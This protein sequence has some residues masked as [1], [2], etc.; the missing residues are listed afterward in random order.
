MYFRTSISYTVPILTTRSPFDG[1]KNPYNG[2][3][4]S[5]RKRYFT[6]IVIMDEVFQKNTP[7]LLNYVRLKN[8]VKDRV[9]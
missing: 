6:F 1:G 8:L 5:Q 4:R 7:N 3:T 9:F 2:E